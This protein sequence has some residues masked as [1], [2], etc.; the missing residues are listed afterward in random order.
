MTEPVDDPSPDPRPAAP[1]EQWAAVPG[2]PAY[3]VSDAGRV[4]SLDRVVMRSNA[5]GLIPM[6]QRGRVLKPVHHGDGHTRVT[7]C[8]MGTK[9][10]AFIHRL[11]LAAFVGPCPEGM[12]GC[13]KNGEPAD[14]R[15][16]NLRWDTGSSNGHDT[17]RHGRHYKVNQTVCL[18]GHLLAEPNLIVRLFREKGH[19]GCLACARATWRMHN[20]RKR[21][22][23]VSFDFQAVADAYYAELLDEAS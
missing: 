10:P 21:H 17:V 23:L 14:N 6:R 11:V 8:S 2:H 9:T 1:T 15:L 20:Q 5:Y 7:L 4:R 3:E 13:H 18:R 12:E 22:G 16:A 19:R